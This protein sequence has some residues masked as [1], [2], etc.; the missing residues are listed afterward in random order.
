[1]EVSDKKVQ[2][3][4][5]NSDETVKRSLLW[6]TI[7][8][9]QKILAQINEGYAVNV[10]LL[11]ALINSCIELLNATIKPVKNEVPS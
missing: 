1:M 8:N 6:T 3:K 11:T 9:I 5:S 2:R 7:Q 10:D 4:G